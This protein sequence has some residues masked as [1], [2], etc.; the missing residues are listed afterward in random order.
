MSVED[1][2]H[3]VQQHFPNAYC[4]SYKNKF[5]IAWAFDLDAIIAVGPK[6]KRAWANA[7]KLLKGKNKKAI[8]KLKKKLMEEEDNETRL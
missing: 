7:A 2:V 5:C 8:E 6:P 4:I 3:A 1:D